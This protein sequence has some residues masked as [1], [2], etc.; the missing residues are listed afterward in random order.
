MMEDKEQEKDNTNA[1][2]VR[3]TDHMVT[4]YELEDR[5]PRW[6]SFAWKDGLETTG[7]KEFWDCP[8]SETGLYR[9]DRGRPAEGSRVLEDIARELYGRRPEGAYRGWRIVD[10]ATLQQIKNLFRMLDVDHR[11]ELMERPIPTPAPMRTFVKAPVKKLPPLP[12]FMK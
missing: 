9:I 4:W 3:I 8:P 2:G 5:K 7:F 12:D 6:K 1:E 11:L 10:H